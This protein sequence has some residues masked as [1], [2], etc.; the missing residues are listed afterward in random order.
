MSATIVN[1]L[2]SASHFER[3][4]RIGRRGAR[5]VW[6]KN[7]VEFHTTQNSRHFMTAS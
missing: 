7:F 2:G 6:G 4:V 5:I 3:I 1:F